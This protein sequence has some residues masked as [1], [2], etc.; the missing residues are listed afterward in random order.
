MRQ[1]LNF[2]SQHWP[3]PLAGIL[4]SAVAFKDR[5]NRRSVIS[6]RC[7]SF[8]FRSRRVRISPRNGLLR[9]DAACGVSIWIPRIRRSIFPGSGAIDTIQR[10][11]DL[12][13]LG[14]L[15]GVGPRCAWMPYC[16]VCARRQFFGNDED[17][18]RIVGDVLPGKEVDRRASRRSRHPQRCSTNRLPL[19]AAESQSTMII[20][21]SP[22]YNAVAASSSVAISHISFQAANA[23]I[24][25]AGRRNR[26]RNHRIQQ[27]DPKRSAFRTGHS[28]AAQYPGE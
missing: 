18:H 23:P 10:R 7:R 6:A 2:Y 24:L 22:R 5:Q 27:C 9:S 19:V 14:V 11:T 25:V 4:L 17:G 13:F 26:T 16:C 3:E 1:V 15:A 20:R 8:R 28:S 12:S 21:W